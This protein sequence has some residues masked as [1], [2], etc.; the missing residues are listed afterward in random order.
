MRRAL[1]FLLLGPLAAAIA[2]TMVLMP[3]P[4][5]DPLFAVIV[6]VAFFFLA[7]PVSMLAGVLDALLAR[8]FQ[9]PSRAALTATAGAIVVSGL[10][11]ALFRGP[12]PPSFLAPFA[13]G[14]AACMWLS[15]LLAADSGV[16]HS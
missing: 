14:A 13:I 4:G 11:C 5:L 6:A 2:A 7:L 15:S 8:R 10:I 1:V 3:L 9:E 12:L 16:R